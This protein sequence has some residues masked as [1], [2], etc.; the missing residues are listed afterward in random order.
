MSLK[1]YFQDSAKEYNSIAWPTRK[2]AIRLTTV[3]IIFV[4]ISSIALGAVDQLLT[5]IYQQFI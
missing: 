3:V 1:S 5:V 4:I 2:Q